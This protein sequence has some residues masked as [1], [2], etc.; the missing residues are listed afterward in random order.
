MEL[1][2]YVDGGSWPA[3]CYRCCWR[4]S[5]RLPHKHMG[6]C[7][8]LAA[9]PEDLRRHAERHARLFGLVCVA[10]FLKQHLHTML[11]CVVAAMRNGILMRPSAMF[12]LVRCRLELRSGRLQRAAAQA[13]ATVK[14]QPFHLAAAA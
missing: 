5:F 14:R 7:L 3:L 9:L 1:M 12:R 10:V 11:T 4:C 2:R 8:L 13:L 6:L